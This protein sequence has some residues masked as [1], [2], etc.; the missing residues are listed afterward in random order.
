MSRG[1]VLATLLFVS[2]VAVSVAGCGSSKDKSATAK[3]TS[4]TAA[5]KSGPPPA[6]SNA[7]DLAHKPK[8]AAPDG[9][10]PDKLVVTDLVAGQGPAAKAGDKL[11]VKYVGIS[12]ST[13]QQFDASWDRHDTFPL[14][15]GA[16]GVIKGWDQGLAGMKAGGR[17]ELVI[18][19]DLGYGAT[20]SGSTIKPYET[21]VFVIDLV[22]IG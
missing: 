9:F 2:L 3:T 20:G 6:V 22:K 17:R 10:P 13:G 8:I 21:L 7:S 16:G 15:L 5:Q 4:S 14:T 1:R 12:W 19:P 11:T 18:P